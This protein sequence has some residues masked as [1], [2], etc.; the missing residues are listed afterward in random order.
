[1]ATD[2]SPPTGRPRSPAD[3]RMEETDN[4]VT[5]TITFRKYGIRPPVYLAGTFSDPPW[6][7]QEMESLT[8]AN[9]GYV[10]VKRIRGEPG[11]KIQ[12]KFRIGEGNWW[13]WDDDKPTVKDM[14]GNVNNE[15]V[16]ARSH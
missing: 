11:T 5:I 16:V 1:M 14:D 4:S 7:H 3:A 10:F 15:L 13:V 8:D 2:D 9:C 12:Y 6:Q